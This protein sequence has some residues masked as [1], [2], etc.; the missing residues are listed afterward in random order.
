VALRNGYDPGT[1]EILLDNI[2]CLGNETS[3]TDC[4]HG[5]WGQHNCKHLEDVACVCVNNT[6]I[7]GN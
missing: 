7:T 1:G 6:D 3:L 2:H 5:G 4:Y